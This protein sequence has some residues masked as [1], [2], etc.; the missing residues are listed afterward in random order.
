MRTDEI[1]EKKKNT[2]CLLGKI[3][4]RKNEW[5]NYKLKIKR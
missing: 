4:C 2:V 1:N 5:L 3:L